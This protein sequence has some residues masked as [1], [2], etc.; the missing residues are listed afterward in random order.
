MDDYTMQQAAIEGKIH[1]LARILADMMLNKS[2]EHFPDYA[3]ARAAEL[4]ALLNEYDANVVKH[5]ELPA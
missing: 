2:G 4:R 3:K 1:A 5:W